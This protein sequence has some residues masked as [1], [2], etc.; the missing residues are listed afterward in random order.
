[1]SEQT[2]YDLSSKA[3]LIIW[4][5]LIFF[6]I[7]LYLILVGLNIYFRSTIEYEQ[8]SKVGSVKS[9]NLIKLRHQEA[10]GLVGIQEAMDQVVREAN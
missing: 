10:E 2:E 4:A 8:Y 1:M 5:Y 7:L 6:V 9:E 3:N